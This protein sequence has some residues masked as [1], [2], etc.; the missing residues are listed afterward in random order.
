MALIEVVKYSGPSG[1]LVWKYPN[2]ELGTWTQLI[3]NESQEAVL[4]KGGRATDTFGPGRHTLSTANIPLLNLIV[5]L[6]FGGD[7]PFTAEVWYINKATVLDVKWGTSSPIQLRDPQYNIIVPVR[8]FGQFGVEVIDARSLLT[9]I[10]GTLPQFDQLSLV[11]YFRGVLMMNINELISGYLIHKK[12]GVL[13]INAYITEIAAEIEAKASRV[14]EEYGIR[15]KHFSC[16]SISVPDDDPSVMRLRA[17]LAKKAEMDI[18]GYTYQQERTFDTLEGAATN[19]GSTQAGT[20]GAGLGMGMGLGIGGA[21]GGQAS[22]LGRLLNTGSTPSSVAPALKQCPNCHTGN[23]AGAKFCSGCGNSLGMLASEDTVTHPCH[24]CGHPLP[25]DAKFCPN[26][27]DRY[28]A[29]PG[30]GA[31]HAPDAAACD[32]CGR[33]LPKPCADCG[34]P[35]DPAAK[36]CPSCGRSTGAACAGCGHELKAGQRFCPECGQAADSGASQA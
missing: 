13:E 16:D 18:V 3:V 15:L 35:I 21:F 5:N 27:G 19:E 17:A 8:A 28:D 25:Q 36:F 14:F 6:P 2:E 29:C 20:M 11:K 24:A 22:E 12:I 34:E 33:E 9:K 23:A 30:C 1:M 31:D 4:Y 32:R 7:S 26:C 10:V